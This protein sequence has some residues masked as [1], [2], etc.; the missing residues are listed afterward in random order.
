VSAGAGGLW[1][2]LLQQMVLCGACLS[3]HDVEGGISVSAGGGYC[4]CCGMEGMK[5]WD[6]GPI[7]NSV[8]VS[9]A[10]YER[11]TR[12]GFLPS[13]GVVSVKIS[14]ECVRGITGTEYCTPDFHSDP[15][16][17]NASDE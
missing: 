3:P 16:G 5:L 4:I 14:T 13:A 15:F 6:V 12:L 8:C 11:T 10:T 9:C 17:P 7:V 2:S 1:R